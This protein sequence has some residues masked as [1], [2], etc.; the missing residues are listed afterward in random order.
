M[1]THAHPRR[2]SLLVLAAIIALALGYVWL[3]GG[4]QSWAND[5]VRDLQEGFEHGQPRLLVSILDSDYPVRERWPDV[6]IY[7]QDSDQD[8]GHQALQRA[9][10][11]FFFQQRQ[12]E[13][14]LSVRQGELQQIAA[15]DGFVT[16][17]LPLSVAVDMPSGPRLNP[18]SLDQHRFVLRQR[19]WFFPSFTIIDH[20]PIPWP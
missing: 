8:L 3:R 11:A 9:L 17:E 2:T 7:A 15:R 5:L 16:Y 10:A 19:G 20:E 14:Q 18:N 13:R 4:P 1:A 12:H 6:S